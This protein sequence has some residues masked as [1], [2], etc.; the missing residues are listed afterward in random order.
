MVASMSGRKL[1]PSANI[2]SI[3][4]TG[5]AAPAES[6]TTSEAAN[7]LHSQRLR[8]AASANAAALYLNVNAM[9]SSAPAAQALLAPE[10]KTPDALE[11][12][13]R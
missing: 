13:L 9:P 3:T 10:V 7:R 1:P 12:A 6:Q 2:S 11:P 4:A 8:M 5:I